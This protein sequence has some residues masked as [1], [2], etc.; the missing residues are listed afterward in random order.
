MDAALPPD[1]ASRTDDVLCGEPILDRGDHAI[2]AGARR[3]RAIAM[4][5]SLALHAAVAVLLVRGA[6]EVS[7][8]ADH[9]D[10]VE[11]IE[12]VATMAASDEATGPDNS[13]AERAEASAAA[14][15][16]VAKEADPPPDPLPVPPPEPHP[17]E[18][19][20]VPEAPLPVAEP[21][22]PHEPERPSEAAAASEARDEAHASTRDHEAKRAAL[23][24]SY[25][26][27]VHEALVRRIARLRRGDAGR[28][29]VEITIAPTGSL[30][31]VRI[32]AGSGDAALDA[33]TLKSVERAAP[34][35]PMPAE[36]AEAPRV[37]LVPFDYRRS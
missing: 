29:L 11:V 23:V 31:A 7:E 16:V 35:Q 8:G 25:D 12:I 13:E 2:R 34:F 18:P 9:G 3:S 20:P 27:A 1:P 24:A 33:A 15:Q 28:V 14:R 5:L 19:P 36:M 10:G 37:L 21:P 17:D 30:V 4:A 26:R 6:T 22:V 32:V